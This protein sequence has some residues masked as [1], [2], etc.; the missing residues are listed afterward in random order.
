MEQEGENRKTLWT[1]TV[2]V[3]DYKAKVHTL[4]I[5]KFITMNVIPVQCVTKITKDTAINNMVV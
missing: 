1:C 3:L 2:I 4:N 5:N